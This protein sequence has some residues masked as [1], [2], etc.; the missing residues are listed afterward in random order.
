MD[1]NTD[2]Y[3]PISY[4]VSP[5]HGVPEFLLEAKWRDMTTPGADATTWRVVE[6]TASFL[7]TV[8][9]RTACTFEHPLS[10]TEALKLA[11][12]LAVRD[13]IRS[14]ARLEEWKDYAVTVTR[15]QLADGE[16]QAARIAAQV[17]RSSGAR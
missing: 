15:D 11:M 7:V 10:P 13:A 12:L 2:G 9:G 1:R 17:G 6:G 5:A 4:M 3:E 16:A 8:T 14:T